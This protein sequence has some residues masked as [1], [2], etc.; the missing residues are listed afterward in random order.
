MPHSLYL[1]SGLVQ[2]RMKEFD[3]SFGTLHEAQASASKYAITIYRPTLSA[4]K[5]CMSYSIAEICVSLFVITLFINAAILI[6]AGTALSEGA[7]TADLPGIY[8]LFVSTIGQASGTVFAFALL[9]SGI[10]A[11][12]VCTMAGQLVCEGALDWRMRPFFRRLLT[13]S[14]SIIPAV[15]IAASQGQLGLAAALNGCNVVL[16]VALI[17]ITFPLVW[18]TSNHKYMRVNIDDQDTPLGIVDGILNHDAIRAEDG[19][20]GRTVS[21]ANDWPT[22]IGA[23]LIWIIVASFNI[24]TLVFLLMGKVDD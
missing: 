10:S 12:I 4:I 22:T 2:T 1:G 17:F 21:L 18:Y 20:E 13:R 24:A 15:I 16:S 3:M 11:G 14:V 8:E 7:A 5:S 23:A 19:G 9:F 6:V